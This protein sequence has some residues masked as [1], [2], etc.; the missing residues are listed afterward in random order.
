M[1]H[2]GKCPKCGKPVLH[3]HV[4]SLN[5]IVADDPKAKCLSFCCIHCFAVLGVQMDPRGRRRPKAAEMTP[6]KPK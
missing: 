2:H 5:G 3:V 1:I 4:E 6:A